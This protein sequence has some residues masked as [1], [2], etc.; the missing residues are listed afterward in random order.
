MV[1]TV[2]LAND[3]AADTVFLIGKGQGRECNK[4][5]VTN[6]GSGQVKAARAK[7][8]LDIPKTKGGIW[9]GWGGIVF[10]RTQ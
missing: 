1:T 9:R 3:L 4:G 6:G 10:A 7:P 5:K 8:E 2:F